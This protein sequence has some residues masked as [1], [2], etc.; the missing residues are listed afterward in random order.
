[1]VDPDTLGLTGDALTAAQTEYTRIHK[2]FSDDTKG[3]I[4]YDTTPTVTPGVVGTPT[5]TTT[6][7]NVTME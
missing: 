1:M 3:I 7:W 2:Q 5:G 6:V 4:V